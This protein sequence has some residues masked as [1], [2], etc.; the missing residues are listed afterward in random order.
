MEEDNRGPIR[1]VLGKKEAAPT[2]APEQEERYG[3]SYFSMAES[4]QTKQSKTPSARKVRP[5]TG[6]RGLV[7]MI[8]IAATA[9][10]LYRHPSVMD[11]AAATIRGWI[12]NEQSEVFANGAGYGAPPAND[13]SDAYI[14]RPNFN[15]SNNENR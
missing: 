2:P 6:Y 10:Y 12:H 14:V 13:D 3:A 4:Q 8:L 11:N 1:P 7:V 5:K 15:N 9:Y